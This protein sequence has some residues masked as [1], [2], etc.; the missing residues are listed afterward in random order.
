[1]LWA[2]LHGMVTLDRNGRLRPDHR[3]ARMD[4]LIAGIVAAE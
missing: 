2:G 4:L 1:V 3:A